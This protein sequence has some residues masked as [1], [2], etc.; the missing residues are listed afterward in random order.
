MGVNFRIN[1]QSDQA[2]NA[3]NDIAKGQK[4]ANVEERSLGLERGLKVLICV[5]EQ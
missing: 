5:I 4:N 1:Y 3:P 2:K